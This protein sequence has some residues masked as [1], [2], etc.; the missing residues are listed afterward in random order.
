MKALLK[1]VKE[2]LEGIQE[3]LKLVVELWLI[4]KRFPLLFVLLFMA[5]GIYFGLRWYVFDYPQYCIYRFYSALGTHDFVTAWNC[6]ADDYR[7][8]RWSSETQFATAY[9]TLASPSDLRVDFPDSKLNPFKFLLEPATKY[10]VQYGE[11]ERFTRDDLRDPQQNE[12]ALWLQIEHPNSYQHLLDGTLGNDNPSLTL[13]RF[14]KESVLV[15]QTQTGWV[16]ASI[17]RTE[18][19][20]K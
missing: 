8:S 4:A 9:K 17:H 19:G 11:E 12:N 6:L 3:I 10:I 2:L 13:N 14:F 18:R 16:I 7:S 20:I 1:Q 15:K 5:F